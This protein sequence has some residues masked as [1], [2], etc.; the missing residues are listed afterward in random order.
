MMESEAETDV[1]IT[2][3][4]RRIVSASSG[5]VPFAKRIIPLTNGRHIPRRGMMVETDWKRASHIAAVSPIQIGGGKQG[6][7]CICFK[8]LARSGRWCIN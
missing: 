5:I 8:T 6:D 2:D 1:A 3:A 4:R 7:M